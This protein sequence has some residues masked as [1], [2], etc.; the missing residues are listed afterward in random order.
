MVSEYACYILES[1]KG[2]HS[3]ICDEVE[4]Y[5]YVKVRYETMSDQ[6]EQS[7]REWS[8]CDKVS[9]PRPQ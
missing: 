8:V 3:R 1:V 2:I 7:E 5:T 6:V 9:I 4:S